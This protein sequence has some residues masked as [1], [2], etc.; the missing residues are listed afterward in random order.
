MLLCSDYIVFD[1]LP[2]LPPATP[3]HSQLPRFMAERKVELDDPF[4]SWRKR[5]DIPAKY[6]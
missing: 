6:W 4:E 3:F 5:K 1:V 2:F